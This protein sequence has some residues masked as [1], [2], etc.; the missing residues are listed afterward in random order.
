MAAVMTL[1]A[2]QVL[3]LSHRMMDGAQCQLQR[4]Q[5][6]MQQHQRFLMMVGAVQVLQQLMIGDCPEIPEHLM[7]RTTTGKKLQC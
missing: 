7:Q 4:L 6:R 1:G 3:Q 5:S 2:I